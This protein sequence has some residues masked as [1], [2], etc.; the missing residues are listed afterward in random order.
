MATNHA[1]EVFVGVEV[2][3]GRS[4]AHTHPEIRH[5]EVRTHFLAAQAQG[6]NHVSSHVW[7]D[8]IDEITI[9]LLVLAEEVSEFHVWRNVPLVVVFGFHVECFVS[10]SLVKII[11]RPLFVRRP[12]FHGTWI[13]N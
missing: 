4:A 8:L 9:R 13:I 11:V 1:E 3:G 5:E 12:V 6:K 10:V 7:Q 2:D